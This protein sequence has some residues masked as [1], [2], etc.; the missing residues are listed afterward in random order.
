[1]DNFQRR[2]IGKSS[3]CVQS[4]LSAV[5][6]FTPRVRILC[7][8]GRVPRV[9]HPSR[10]ASSHG[11]THFIS[12]FSVGYLRAFVNL[13]KSNIEA[14]PSCGFRSARALGPSNAFCW[15]VRSEKHNVWV[16]DDEPAVRSF[17]ADF[18]ASRGYGVLCLDSG[19]HVVARLQPANVPS[20][21]LLDI[22][23]PRLG[24]LEVMAELGNRG[25]RVPTIVLS[26]LDEA[27]TVVKAMRLGALDY[28]VKPLDES[29]LELAIEKALDEQEDG[30]ATGAIEPAQG[31]STIN[32]RMLQIRAISDQVAH[33]DVPILILGESGVG[34]DVLARYIHQ[35]SGRS[36]PFIRVNCAALPADLLESEL[37]GHERGAFTGAQRDKPGKFEL[38]GSGTIMLDEIGEMSTALQAKLLHVLQ[39]G[40]YCRVGGTRTLTS[41]ARILAATNK[42]PEKMVQS[43]AFR[44]DLL[45]RLNVITVEVPPLRERPEDIVPLCNAFLEKYRAKYK[46]PVQEL[47]AELLNAFTRHP[48]PGNIRQLENNVKRFLILPDVR[49]ALLELQRGKLLP[50]SAQRASGSLKEQS[51]NAAESAE[52]ELILRTLNEVN[53]N[54]K[55]AA[56]RLDICYKSLLNKLH[57]WEVRGQATAPASADQDSSLYT[58]V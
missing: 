44:E 35:K 45:F 3:C 23:M 52:K 19:E 51:A 7:R 32:K 39:D 13:T 9:K 41:D 11:L 31:F 5:V 22:R 2:R 30:P 55:Q 56:R 47:P 16:A 10:C 58:A 40:E 36:G 50:E 21:L 28:L 1:M 8:G 49:M 43:G 4:L 38:A 53:W 26:G 34:K 33:A 37:F 18:L 12:A 20:L 15:G 24:G 57:R 25:L 48:W 27:S 42:N 14:E 17:L 6:E 29:D 46:S 54:R